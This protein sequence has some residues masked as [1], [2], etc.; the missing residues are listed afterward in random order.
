MH[1]FLERSL[2]PSTCGRDMNNEKNR[3]YNY[4]YL[5]YGFSVNFSQPQIV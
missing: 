4:E 2:Q 1:I 3:L 5:K